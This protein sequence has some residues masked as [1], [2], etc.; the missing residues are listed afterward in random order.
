MFVIR[1]LLIKRISDESKK[2]HFIHKLFCSKNNFILL[3]MT[4]N[5]RLFCT[6]IKHGYRSFLKSRQS[7]TNRATI[8]KRITNYQLHLYQ[9]N[10]SSWLIDN[11]STN[12][13]WRKY[14]Y[15]LYSFRHNKRW[16]FK[17]I[18]SYHP[19]SNVDADFSNGKI[20][21][22][23]VIAKNETKQNTISNTLPKQYSE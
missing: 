10:Y 9:R 19:T 13:W 16:L 2:N 3:F 20:V 14:N 11:C 6:K 23:T 8:K 4:H 18:S 15:L 12:H 5:K 22:Y 1:I 21:T 7:Q 17:G